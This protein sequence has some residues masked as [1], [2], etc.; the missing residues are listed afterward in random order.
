M[1]EPEIKKNREDNFVEYVSRIAQNDTGFAA[2]MRRA[3]NRDTEDYA[4]EILAGWGIDLQNDFER[5]PYALVGAAI[6]REKNMTVGEKGI[7]ALLA[8]SCGENSDQGGARLRRLLA[9]DNVREA[10]MVLRQIVRLLQARKPGELSYSRLLKDL[11]YFTRGGAERVKQGWAM[12]F[13]NVVSPRKKA[14]EA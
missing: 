10:C 7:G 9:C 14:D 11:M 3:D 6:C 8:E 2:K 4:W 5:L 1:Q 12:D 13:Y